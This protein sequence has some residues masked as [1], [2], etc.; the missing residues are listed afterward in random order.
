MGFK[1]EEVGREIPRVY[2]ELIGKVEI[3]VYIA[4]LVSI[5]EKKNNGADQAC[6]GVGERGWV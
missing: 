4:L 3:L 5:C 2:E 1:A 6:W